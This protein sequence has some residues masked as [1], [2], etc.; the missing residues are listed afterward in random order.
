[1]PTVLTNTFPT[2][3]RSGQYIPMAATSGTTGMCQGNITSIAVGT[4]ATAA[5]AIDSAG[6]RFPWTTGT[7]I[8]SLCG[9][10]CSAVLT[11]ERDLDPLIMAKIQWPTAI[12][13]LRGYFG[14]TSSNAAPASSADPLPS[15]SGVGFWFDSG[16][17]ATNIAIA[18][19]DGSASSDTTT[20]AAAGTASTSVMT[21]ALKANNANSKFQYSIAGGAW[22]DINTKIPAAGTD[23]GWTCFI[24]CL[25]GSAA[26]G[27]NV[28]WVQMECDG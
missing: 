8:N 11:M 6:G 16:V 7:T 3:R 27:L 23:L 18:Q 21:L 28:Y 14:F 19:N 12:T 10:R 13:T 5:Y 1:M 24:E 15:L 17:H 2:F 20:I 26:R 4:G 25:A 22:S 9:V